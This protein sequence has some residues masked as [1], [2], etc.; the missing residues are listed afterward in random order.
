MCLG[1]PGQIIAIEDSER[2][3]ATIDV[4][5]IRRQVNIACVVSD[6]YPPER[7]IGDWVLVHVGFAMSRID[8]AEAQKTLAL[9]AEL[10]EMQ[11]EMA[12][13]R[14]DGFGEVAS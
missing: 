6:D 8:A 1:I 12:V 14:G 9:L 7:C 2:C 10:D 3:M 4:A 13:K 11:D 5:G